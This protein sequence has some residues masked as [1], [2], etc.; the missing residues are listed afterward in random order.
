MNE[1]AD[2]IRVVM[3]ATFKRKGRPGQFMRA[4]D[5]LP[6]GVQDVLLEHL[7]LG[8]GE[9]AVIGYAERDRWCLLTTERISWGMLGDSGEL[10]LAHIAS[11]RMDVDAMLRN[12]GRKDKVDELVLQTYEGMEYLV[13][14][15]TGGS[16]SSVWNTL[17]F[18]IAKLKRDGDDGVTPV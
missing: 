17:N 3:L 1:T 16:M 4:F 18:M 10:R 5:E 14:V 11:A 2:H 13:P 6:G 7:T 12:G 9:R 15:E 8:A